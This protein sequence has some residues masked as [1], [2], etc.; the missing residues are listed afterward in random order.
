MTYMIERARN[1]LYPEWGATSF[2]LPAWIGRFGLGKYPGIVGRAYAHRSICQQAESDGI[3][4]VAPMLIHFGAEPA[5]IRN[6][7]G[8]ER[9]KQMHH[10]TLKTNVDRLVLLRLAG[11]DLVEAMTFPVA[12]Q[13]M[14]AMALVRASRPA[15][16]LACRLAEKRGELLEFLR[17]AIDT[18]NMGVVLDPAWGRKRLRREHEAAILKSFIAKADPTPWAK[19]WFYD[20]AGFTFSLMKSATE[21]AMEGAIQRHCAA[22]YVKR[23]RAGETVVLQISGDVRATC[24]WDAGS[25]AIQVKGFANSNVSNECR[26]AAKA[27]RRAYE[28]HLAETR[29]AT[30]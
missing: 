29:K 9:W 18:Q 13:Q 6:Q 7:I 28:K 11:W 24:S 8:G 4:Q 30:P 15:A 12:E 20:F 1:S 21:L 27:A 19:A 17:L 10:A 22:S 5:A 3:P 26:A 23:C 14:R 16:M 2:T 25:S